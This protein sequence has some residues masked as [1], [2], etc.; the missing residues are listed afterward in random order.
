MSDEWP[1][2]VKNNHIVSFLLEKWGSF[3]IIE[4][5][6]RF[7][8]FYLFATF[9]FF[10]PLIPPY[11]LLLNF[12]GDLVANLS[13]LFTFLLLDWS[14]FRRVK[15]ENPCLFFFLEAVFFYFL[16]IRFNVL[17]LSLYSS[18]CPLMVEYTPNFT[19]FFPFRFPLWD[20]YLSMYYVFTISL[21]L[22]SFVGLWLLVLLLCLDF[23]LSVFIALLD[24]LLI[25]LFPFWFVRYCSSE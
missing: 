20:L 2:W 25:R 17:E 14:M 16:L 4:N 3:D 8:F 6:D 1:E 12:P 21:I 18:S 9:P 13:L 19:F 24:T 11:R 22:L 7:A 5:I 23:D 10:P 15:L